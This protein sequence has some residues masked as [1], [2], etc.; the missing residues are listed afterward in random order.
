MLIGQAQRTP[1]IGFVDRSLVADG[2]IGVGKQT[3]NIW[4]P[5]TDMFPHHRQ[6][7]ALDAMGSFVNE[8]YAVKLKNFIG[9]VLLCGRPYEQHPADQVFAFDELV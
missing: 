1:H 9:I 8:E 4:Q 2:W 3:A 6:A 5:D 7:L